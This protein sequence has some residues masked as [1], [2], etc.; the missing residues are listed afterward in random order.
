MNKLSIVLFV[1]FSIFSQQIIGCMTQAT[2]PQRDY[3]EPN[4]GPTG[5]DMTGCE[6]K[7][8]IMTTLEA[9]SETSTSENYRT[10][11]IL[12]LESMETV[13]AVAPFSEAPSSEAPFE[14][15]A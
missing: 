14:H 8:T 2:T 6:V 1:I 4:W 3:I 11:D 10:S 15:I 9:S 13:E 5:C 12:K 7:T